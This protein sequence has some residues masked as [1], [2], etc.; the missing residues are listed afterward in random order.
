MKYVLFVCNHNAGRSQ[1]AQAFFERYAPDDIRAESAGDSP[2]REVWPEV[3]EAMNEV[4]IDLSKHKPRKLL[5]EMQLHADWAITL[6]CGAACPYVPTTVEDWPIED[7]AGRPLEQVRV[8]RDEIEDR[9]KDLLSSRLDEIRADD[10]AHQLRLRKFL[11]ELITEFEGERS[12]EE[13]RDCTDAILSEYDDAPV[14][15]FLAP[16]VA[17]RA[18]ECLKAE[19]CE[20]L[21]A[22]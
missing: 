11:P 6:N 3:I 13:I 17:R 18:R 14:R 7:P 4:G 8:I 10:T 22:A 19:S 2:A 9:V 12:A 5:P 16:I 15:G 21:V 20:A 1:M